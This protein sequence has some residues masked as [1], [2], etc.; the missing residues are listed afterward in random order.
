VDSEIKALKNE[1]KR[2]RESIASYQQRIENTPRREQELQEIA[3]DYLPTKEQYY[4]LLKGYQE[5]QL[6]NG[7]EQQQSGQEFR[8]LDPAIP[9]TQPAAPDRNR[10]LLFGLMF[11]L[12]MAVV[13]V[14]LAEYL[15]ASF[16]TL[17]ELRA[18]TKLPVLVAIPKIVTATDI[19]HRWGRFLL[20]CFLTM[21]GL[22]LIVMA[23]NY[24]AHENHQLALMLVRSRPG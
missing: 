7:L 8:I 16:H 10:L 24:I 13:A 6:A 12:G 3:P 4:A 18:F 5:A 11:S 9:E 23:S 20:G 22:V 2:L 14:V 17:D 19:R 1:D 15:D 21:A